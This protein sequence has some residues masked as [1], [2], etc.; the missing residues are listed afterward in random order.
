MDTL[1]GTHY[2]DPILAALAVLVALILAAAFVVLRGVKQ[3]PKLQKVT[4]RARATL[5]DCS[6]PGATVLT[7]QR[8]HTAGY[9]SFLPS[10]C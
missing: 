9:N 2:F 8:R 6:S 7:H 1:L 4:P 10:L 5:A 3:L